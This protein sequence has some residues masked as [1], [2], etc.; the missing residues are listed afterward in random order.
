MDLYDEEELQV[1]NPVGVD[2]FPARVVLTFVAYNI[3]TAASVVSS[4]L[5]PVLNLGNV[6][7]A[8]TFDAWVS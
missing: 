7:M 8:S 6:T 4:T 5:R 1:E 2:S 3:T